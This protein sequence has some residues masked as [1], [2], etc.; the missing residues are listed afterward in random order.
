MTHH[1][2]YTPGSAGGG[3]NVYEFGAERFKS[4]ECIMHIALAYPRSTDLMRL[5]SSVKSAM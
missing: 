1:C 2:G 4:T 3:V 5:A